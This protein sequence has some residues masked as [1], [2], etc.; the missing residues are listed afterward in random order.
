MRTLQE[1]PEANSKDRTNTLIKQPRA[2]KRQEYSFVLD[3][4]RNSGESLQTFDGFEFFTKY[5]KLLFISM[6]EESFESFKKR[7]QTWCFDHCKP[8]FDIFRQAVRRTAKLLSFIEFGHGMII[9]PTR[10]LCG[11]QIPSVV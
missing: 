5:F 9:F 6:N 4:F 2:A 3:I 10:V 8:S 7:S 1:D 11:N